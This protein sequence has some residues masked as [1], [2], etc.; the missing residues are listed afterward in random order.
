VAAGYKEIVLT[1]INIGD[2]DGGEKPPRRLEELVRLVDA[3]EGVERIR[4]SSIDPDEVDDDLAAHVV[5]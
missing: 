1:G 5:P 2:F 3:I 4:V